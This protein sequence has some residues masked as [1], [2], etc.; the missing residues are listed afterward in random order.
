MVVHAFSP[1][2]G[3]WISE[4]EAKP[5]LYSKVPV[6]QTYSVR[7]CLQKEKKIKEETY[8]RLKTQSSANRKLPQRFQE[9]KCI[10][11]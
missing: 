1:N 8:I 11:S 10:F 6:N 2:K 7:P 9:K 4:F 5:D 3:R